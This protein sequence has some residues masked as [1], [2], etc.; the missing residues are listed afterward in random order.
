MCFMNSI[1]QMLN[2]SASMRDILFQHGQQHDMLGQLCA[3][4]VL[5]QC[6]LM[7]SVLQWCYLPDCQLFAGYGYNVFVLWSSIM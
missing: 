7:Y 1:V 4:Y 5:R 6:V 3:V 2:A